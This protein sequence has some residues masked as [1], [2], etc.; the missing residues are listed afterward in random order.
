MSD[1]SQDIVD[2]IYTD[3]IN[4]IEKRLNA[5]EELLD[6]ALPYIATAPDLYKPGGDELNDEIKQFL[7]TKRTG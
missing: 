3:M 2:D 7:T 5:A 4:V 6:R 1:I